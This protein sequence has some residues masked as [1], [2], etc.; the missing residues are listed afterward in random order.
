MYVTRRIPA[1]FSSPTF[2]P[3]SFANYGR[4]RCSN[5]FKSCSSICDLKRLHAYLLTQGLASSLHLA[6]KLV[7]LASALSPTMEYARKLFELMADRDSFLWNTLIRGY[8]TIGPCEEVP[9]LYKEMHLAGFSPDYYTFPF[10]VRSC[11][12]VSA[13]REGKQVHCS[14]VKNGLDSNIFAQG[15]LITL[16]S[17]SGEISDAELGFG[18]MDERV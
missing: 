6:T 17:Q 10:V 2:L 15:S 4:L 7:S 16:Y 11:A 18:E 14:I 3:A 8:A 1:H 9:G 13:I 5:L 12:V